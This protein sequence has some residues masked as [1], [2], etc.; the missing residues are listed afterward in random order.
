[1]LFPKI[2]LFALSVSALSAAP[3]LRLAMATAGPVAVVTGQNGPVQIVDAA[4]LGDG[5]L[6]LTAAASVPWIGASVGPRRGCALNG[7]C[8]PVQMALNTASLG[9]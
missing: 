6:S 1:M 5:T 4:N 2:L 9:K 8:F 3:K 7:V